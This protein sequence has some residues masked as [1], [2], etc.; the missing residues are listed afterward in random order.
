MP[1]LRA[2]G[3]RVPA[4]CRGTFVLYYVSKEHAKRPYFIAQCLRGTVLLAQGV[5]R[6]T[7]AR[8]NCNMDFYD[9]ATVPAF[10]VTFVI[11]QMTSLII[12]VAL[13]PFYVIAGGRYTLLKI[14]QRICGPNRLAIPGRPTTAWPRYFPLAGSAKVHND[15]SSV[16]SRGKILLKPRTHTYH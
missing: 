7:S 5:I 9:G 8:L 14:F 13:A 10:L 11:V 12:S 16:A 4:R 2:C 1:W 6:I 3:V 15:L